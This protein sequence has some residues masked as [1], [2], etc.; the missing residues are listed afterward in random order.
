MFKHNLVDAIGTYTAGTPLIVL[1]ENG[2]AGVSD[3]TSFKSRLMVGGLLFL[4]LGGGIGWL[5]DKSKKLCKITDKSKEM[6]QQAHDMTYIAGISLVINPTVYYVSGCRDFKEIV[7]GTLST[8]G[9]A[10]VTGG[11]IGYS[12]DMYRVLLRDQQSERI[13]QVIQQRGKIAKYA[14]AAGIFAASMGFTGSVYHFSPDSV[15]VE[16]IEL[17]K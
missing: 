16:T 8:M 10:L 4:G 6:Y 13:P 9:V 12:M 2:F 11:A 15:E 5:R 3:E 1:I 14:L 17:E 7:Y